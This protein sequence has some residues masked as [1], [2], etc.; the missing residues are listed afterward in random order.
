MV[1]IYCGSGTSV[2]NSRV[3]KLSN[4][5][6][7]RRKCQ[8]C[9]AIFTSI[10]KPYYPTS[11]VISSNRSTVLP[12]LPEKLFLSVYEC[13]KHRQ[14][15][16]EDAKHICDTI[17]RKMISSSVDDNEIKNTEL[18][19]LVNVTLNRFDRTAAIHYQAFHT[20]K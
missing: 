4:G 14:N 11:I 9:N 7:R 19:N 1:C 13:L 15:P 5:V 10:E 16:I 12:F 20:N 6:W 8:R 2:V 3:Q 17:T 18:R